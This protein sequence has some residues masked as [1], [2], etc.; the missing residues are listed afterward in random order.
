MSRNPK[1]DKCGHRDTYLEQQQ[2][3]NI[4]TEVR[5]VDRVRITERV[6]L[7][8]R[9]AFYGGRLHLIHINLCSTGILSSMS[10]SN[11]PLG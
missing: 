5:D 7:L 1:F 9:V 11:S 4:D 10:S 8:S 2:T 3:E 6:C